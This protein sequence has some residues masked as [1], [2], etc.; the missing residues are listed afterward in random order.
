MAKYKVTLTEPTVYL[1]QGGKAVTGF[2]VRVY[3]P[4]FDEIHEL[5]VPNLKPETVKVAAETLLEQREA[6]ALLGEEE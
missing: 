6:L 2:L 1:D 5:R 4:D 3:F